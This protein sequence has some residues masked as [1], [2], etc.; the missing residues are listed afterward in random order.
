MEGIKKRL[1]RAKRN[2][3]YIKL[4]FDYPNSKRATVRRG[5]VKEVY[6]DSFD[7]QED[8]DEEVTYKY[9]YIVEIKNEKER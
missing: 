2:K 4:I 1:E 9:K 8:K 3:E 6:E 5:Y 7:M